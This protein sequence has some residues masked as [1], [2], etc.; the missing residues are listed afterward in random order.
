MQLIRERKQEIC[1]KVRR[2]DTEVKIRIG[3]QEYTPKQWKKLLERFDETE[4]DIREKLAQAREQ[5]R[6]AGA[7]SAALT[8]DGGQASR[9]S[10]IEKLLADREEEKLLT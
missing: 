7:Q 4:D 6:R 10:L 8:E 3:A 1:D 9:E 5:Q 2:G